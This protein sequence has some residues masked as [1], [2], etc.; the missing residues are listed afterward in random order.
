MCTFENCALLEAEKFD[1]SLTGTLLHYHINH[2]ISLPSLYI[3][4]ITD[5]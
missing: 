3:S 2:I 1:F 4:S 5:L